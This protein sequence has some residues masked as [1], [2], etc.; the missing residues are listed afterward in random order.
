MFARRR[1]RKRGRPI[2]QAIQELRTAA[3]AEA[4]FVFDRINQL[5]VG[6]RE[7]GQEKQDLTARDTSSPQTV[8]EVGAK[9][10]SSCQHYA[11]GSYNECLLGYTDPNNKI[12]ILENEKGNPIARSIFRLLATEDGK[13]ALH[14]EQIYSASA[15]P[16]VVGVMYE[17][18]YKKAQALN[19][20]LFVSVEAQNADGIE[21]PVQIPSGFS[22]NPFEKT[23][24]SHSSRAPFVYVD[25]AGGVNSFGKYKIKNVFE[26][27]KEAAT[28]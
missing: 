25:S 1:E 28:G 19:M 17:H 8:I 18:G 20:P 21:T 22:G 9:P 27:T 15:S 10:V 16:S 26:V 2:S 24:L 7:Q 4:A 13:P 6:M 12:L 11:H 5:L 3:P 23:L 14:L